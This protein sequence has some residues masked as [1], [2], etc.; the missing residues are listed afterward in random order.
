MANS[1]ITSRRRVTSVAALLVAA[2]VTTGCA[3]AADAPPQ[4][5]TFAIEGANLSAGHM[6]PH[7]SQLD[8]SAMV[9]RNVLDSL[10]AQDL[11][12]EFVPWLA[13]SWEISDDELEYTF[14]LR[15]DVTFHDGEPFNAEAVKANFDHVTAP[16]TVSAQ[17]ASMIGYSADGG[18]YIGTEVVDEY[19]VRMTFSKPYAP[20]LQAVSTSSLGFYSPKVLAEQADQLKTGGPGITVGTG[21]FILTEYTPD[22]ELVFTAN[23]DYQ[24]APANAEHSGPSQLETLTISI[25]PEAAVRTGALTSGEAQVAT[26]ISPS[27]V[28]QLG[29]DI[30]VNSIELPGLPYSLFLNEKYGVF[31]DENVRKAFSIG[32]DLDSAIDSVFFGQYTRAWSILGP[33]SPNSYDPT[34]EGS[35]PFDADAANALLD[36]SGWTGRDSDGYRTKGGERLSARWISWTPVPD[37]HAALADVI[38][39]D[40]KKI[41]F[42]IVREPLEPAAYNEQYIPKTFDI[43][44]WNFPAVDADILRNH[45]YSTGF[46]NASQVAYPAVDSL[47]DDAVATSNLAERASNYAQLQQW[48]ADH[49]AIVP[50]YVASLITAESSTVSGLTFDLYGRA[51]FYGASLSLGE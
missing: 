6:D 26:D 10:V 4:E 2:F 41:G 46:Q 16:E 9:M 40:L 43:T 44:D 19:T 11:S 35:W 34:L 33:T 12:G 45:L 29:N 17:A 14:S 51:L 7:S 27:T 48:N 32:F 31:A 37:D 42:E 15:D 18:S 23:P 36:E 38:Q 47:L 25:V 49:N 50:I 5:L 20:F 30:T 3:T 13:T 24:W 39:S 22:Q 1:I 28:S 21:P 8:V